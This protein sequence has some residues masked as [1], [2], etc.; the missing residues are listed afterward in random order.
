MTVP[1]WISSAIGEFGRAA[2]LGSFALS[3][4]GVAAM[5]FENGF[6]L[7]F[8]Y[9]GGRL[10]VAMTFPFALDEDNA[11]RLLSF[12]HPASRGAF[13]MRAGYMAKKSKAFFAISLDDGD[14]TLPA[15]NAAFTELWRS[16]QEIGGAS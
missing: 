16:A 3:A 12:A 13:R 4:Q 5:N 8:E 9:A 11:T 14:V 1:D 15:I 10:V 2:G 7:R 6:A